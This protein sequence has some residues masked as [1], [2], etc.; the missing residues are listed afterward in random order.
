MYLDQNVDACIVTRTNKFHRV[1]P[2]PK[3]LC[4]PPGKQWFNHGNATVTF[5]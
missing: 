5:K 2:S 4:W 1:T 3:G